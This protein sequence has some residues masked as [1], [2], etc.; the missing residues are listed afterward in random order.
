MKHASLHFNSERWEKNALYWIWLSLACGPA[1]TEFRHL[2]E[3]YDDPYEL[4][5]LSEEEIEQMKWISPSLRARL[6][7]KS[8]SESESILRFCAPEKIDVLPYGSPEYPTLLME[9]SDPPVVLYVRGRMPDLSHRICLGMVGTR[10]ISEYGTQTSYRIAYELSAANVLVVSGMAL[11]V[12]GVSACGALMQGRETIAVLGCG[13]MVTYP[14]EHKRLM[15]AIIARGAVISEYPPYEKPQRYYFPQRNRIISGLSRGVMVIEGR[16]KSGSMITAG[17]AQMQGRDLFALPG[18]VDSQGGEGPN[19]LIQDGAIMVTS[20]R[21]ILKRYYFLFKEWIDVDGY[22]HACKGK[23]PSVDEVLV[24]FGICETHDPVESVVN[25]QRS[26]AGMPTDKK[27]RS[28]REKQR[29]EDLPA[30]MPRIPQ[31]T[32]SLAEQPMAELQATSE[33]TVAAQTLP[34][35][36]GLSDFERAILAAMPQGES[37]APDQILLNEG[38]PADLIASLSM[39]SI[40]G[41]VESEPGGMYK[42]I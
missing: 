9:I 12:D 33:P 20:S 2:A 37:V 3:R 31:P 11:G 18:R 13:V 4:Y 5:S 29:Q 19:K 24:Q 41:F 27:H 32:E 39:L 26:E 21:D 28:R 16:A 35:T 14:R 36:D 42:K 40:L 38:T 22:N 25:R 30:A 23:I 8:L 10:S 15:N 1:N 6:S 7:N 34:S 17:L